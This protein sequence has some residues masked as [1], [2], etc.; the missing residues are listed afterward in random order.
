MTSSS[1][2]SE[3][4]FQCSVCLNMF[5]DPVSVPCGHSFCRSCIC[6]VWTASGTR[7]CPKCSEVFAGSLELH[8][9][10]FAREMAEQI[11]S[12]R[13][14]APVRSLAAPGEVHCDVCPGRRELRAVRS[15]LVCLASYCEEHLAIHNNRF[16]KH[17]LV[18][19]VQRLEERMCQKHERP[20]ELFC[21]YDQKCICVLCTDTDHSTH[22]IVPVEREWAEKKSQLGGIQDN[23]RQMINERLQ[24]VNEIKQ[25]VEMS[26]KNTD[27]QIAE[28]AE[29]FTVLLKSIERRRV[30]LLEVMEEK[31]RT[32][33]RHAQT[34]IEELEREISGLKKRD[35]ELE[36]LSHTEDH[37][38]FLQ[39]FLS[40]RS[41]PQHKDWSQISV[42]TVQCVGMLRE[43]LSQLDGQLRTHIN[44]QTETELE[45]ISHYAV[46]LTLDPSTAN[47]WLELSADGRRVSD[48]EIERSVPNNPQRFDTAPCVLARQAV[49]GGRSY[50][51]VEVTNKTAWDL[52]VVRQSISR[53]GVVTL[54]PEDGYWAI[55]LRK[56]KEYRAC[57]KHSVL[58]KLPSKPH[59]V[60]LFVDFDEGCIS[61]FDAGTRTHIYSFTGFSFIEPLL[62]FFNPEMSDSGHNRAPLVI[63]PASE[64]S[65]ELPC[66]D[67]TI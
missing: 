28:S 54:S 37:L 59:K 21:R 62:P 1:H 20:L 22:H 36:K 25:S 56:G 38:H 19:P 26:R 18:E 44:R 31:Q 46:D 55:C 40:V 58:L 39:T 23:V 4:L 2:L 32:V 8:D 51:E 29:V 33:E 42:H 48:G 16:T 43:A 34:L 53:K 61:F 7:H 5:T 11:R 14:N 3:E 65:G 30:E 67:I 13:Q 15:C 6:G 52:G 57:D 63:L 12:R 24:K 27:K 35:V 66:E 17:T 45:T 49:T 10:A 41:P 9:N 60:G 50:W 64:I 47:P